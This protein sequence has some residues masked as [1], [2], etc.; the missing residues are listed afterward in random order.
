[1]RILHTAD[2]H[3]GKRL[4]RFSRLEEQ[5][6]V[7]EEICRIADEIRV[8]VVLIAGDLFDTFNPPT[9]AIEL[10]YTIL[11]KLSRNGSRAVVA[12]AGNHDSP[13]RIEAPDPLARECGILLAGY[14]H[15]RFTPFQLDT[16][17]T[18]L[19]SD[20]GFVEL[21]LPSADVPLRLLLTPYANE[22]RLKT[23]LGFEESENE[24]GT[25]LQQKWQHLSD[26][27][28]DNRGVNILMTHLFFIKQG[29]TPGEEPEEEKPILH[30]GGA[31]AVYAENVPEQIQYVALGHLH[32]KR[33]VAEAPCPMMYSSSPLAY[34]MS[35]A[36]QTKYVI[37]IEAEPGEE[38]QITEVPLHSG[39]SLYRKRFESVDDAITW[40]MEH[41]DCLVE[42]TMSTETYLTAE[43]RKRLSEAHSG[44]V[45]IIPI[46]SGEENLAGET[47]RI[48]N[49]DK[50]MEELFIDYFQYRYNQSPNRDLLELFKEVLAVRES[51]E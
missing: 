40:L 28:C 18:V 15:T 10:F 34:S 24:L 6:E 42:L 44:I 16:G 14:P 29:E 17:L 25:L 41:P 26:I 12:I 8:D 5:R 46:V 51:G 35:E 31:R 39:K 49:L 2:W 48:I 33:L 9:E 32:G 37:L 30:V 45:S 36:D 27:Y 21:K 19:R 13:D 11:K 38:A 20:E 4:D 43:E 23:F 47:S 22:L 3:L 1:M 7:L 50:S